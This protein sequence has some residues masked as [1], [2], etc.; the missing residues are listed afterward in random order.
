MSLPSNGLNTRYGYAIHPS[1]FAKEIILKIVKDNAIN[2]SGFGGTYVAKEVNGNEAEITIDF[3]VVTEYA[4]LKAITAISSNSANSVIVND[5]QF[6]TYG[7]VGTSPAP[8]SSNLKDDTGARTFTL[9][10]S[11][12]P[13][14]DTLEIR[15][16]DNL[17]NSQAFSIPI[18][19]NTTNIIG[20]KKDANKS[21]ESSFTIESDG[22]MSITSQEQK[23]N[24]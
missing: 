15:L 14:S 22:T 4:G 18:I 3:G 17:G 20:T 12:V 10:Y 7:H 8:T 23:G 9:H 5:D 2:F 1:G 24:N 6:K 19:I 13:S 21:I 16:E 11:S